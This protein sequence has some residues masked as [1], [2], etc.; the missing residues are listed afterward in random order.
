MKP[1]YGMETENKRGRI[2][3]VCGEKILIGE[4]K[5][6][7]VSKSWI[8]GKVQRIEMCIECAF[9]ELETPDE[10]VAKQAVGQELNAL[11]LIEMVGRTNVS[12]GYPPRVW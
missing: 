7:Q 8:S 2:C 3:Q 12:N 10:L 1:C 4:A 5:L 11:D 9:D 6:I